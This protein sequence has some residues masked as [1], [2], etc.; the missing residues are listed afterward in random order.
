[1]R[2]AVVLDEQIAPNVATALA[3]LDYPME[4]VSAVDGLGIGTPDVKVLEHCGK[5]GC[6]LMTIDH[7]MSSRP[8]ERAAIKEFGVGV[9]FIRS[10]RKDVLLPPEIVSLI[11]NRWDEIVEIGKNEKRPF[12]KRLQPGQR[13]MDYETKK[14]RRK[15]PSGKKKRRKP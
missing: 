1:M 6:V 5:H 7:K 15:G 4:H 11:L 14:R 8:Q 9:L 13:I 12:M 3:A 10:G 2:L